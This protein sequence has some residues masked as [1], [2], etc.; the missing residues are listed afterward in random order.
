MAVYIE[1]M[2]GSVDASLILEEDYQESYEPTEEGRLVAVTMD[3]E[4]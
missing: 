3:T 2:D 1:A 4:T